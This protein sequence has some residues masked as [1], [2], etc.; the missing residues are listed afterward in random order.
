MAKIAVIA[1]IAKMAVMAVVAIMAVMAVMALIAFLITWTCLKGLFTLLIFP[2]PFVY[3][4][5]GKQSRSNF[6]KT[7]EP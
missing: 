5:N 2:T 4:S 1:K 7:R 3:L 6:F